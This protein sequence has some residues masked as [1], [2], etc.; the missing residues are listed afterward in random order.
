MQKFSVGLLV[1]AAV[2]TFLSFD[3][4]PKEKVNWISFEELE[5]AYAKQP[6]PIIVDLYTNWCGWCKEMDRTTYSNAKVAAYINE[7][8]YAVKYNA[9]STDS[10]RFNKMKYGFNKGLKTNELALY[11]SFG[12]RSYP[13][14]IFLSSMNARPA[15]LSGYM[16][17]K[18][19][20]APLRYFV[21][22][23]GDQTFVEFNQTMK[24]NW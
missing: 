5:K 1:F 3:S 19:I 13:N 17:P 12:E 11:L 10:V 15:P 18:E 2:F 23:K 4:K 14:T 24:A 22:K 6:K 9:E 8:Y 20:E 16:K 21:E 7:N